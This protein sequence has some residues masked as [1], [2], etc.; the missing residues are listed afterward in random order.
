MSENPNVAI[1]RESYDAL[2]KGD[3]DYI[4]DRLL[5][6]EVVFHVPGRGPLVGDYR[7][8]D[9]VVRYLTQY[10]DLAGSAVRLEPQEFLSGEDHVAALVHA[11]GE[12]DGRVLDD[13]GVH[14]FRISNGKIS[15]RWS[16]PQDLYSTDAFFA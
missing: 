3:L 12:R 4:R 5:A 9:E 11:R 7:G 15:E 16:Y 2:A 6:D 14:L 1:A 10:S 8:K 13:R